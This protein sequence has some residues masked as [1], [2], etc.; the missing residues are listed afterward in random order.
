MKNT[1]TVALAR[2]FSIRKSGSKCYLVDLNCKDI[3]FQPFELDEEQY[4]IIRQLDG[5]NTLQE[6][7]DSCENKTT[8][9]DLIE[10]LETIKALSVDETR[11]FY[12]RAV[13]L[14]V[15]S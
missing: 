6:I 2:T 12:P 9:R 3:V 5:S 11:E 10:D 14:L 8:F 13:Q 7:E 1:K 4:R 15:S